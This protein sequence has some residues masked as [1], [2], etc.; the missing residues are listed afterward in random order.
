MKSIYTIS[1]MIYSDKLPDKGTVEYV[2]SSY[3]FLFKA[4]HE[5]KNM[6]IMY[7]NY[8]DKWYDN[9]FNK[10]NLKIIEFEYPDD[11]T[12]ASGLMVDY[13][14]NTY[15]LSNENEIEVEQELSIQSGP[16][17]LFGTFEVM[18]NNVSL[19]E[20]EQSATSL[21]EYDNI[22]DAVMIIARYLQ[23]DVRK[24]LCK[25]VKVLYDY[26]DAFQELEQTDCYH[27]DVL[28]NPYIDEN[29]ALYY[30]LRK[31]IEI[32]RRTS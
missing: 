17:F 10:L 14:N 31:F 19:W 3:F 11:I 18:L 7:M 26:D 23:F 9:A 30:Q 2:I 8:I 21:F 4:Y 13:I 5:S 24:I 25:L 22:S 6:I 20:I 27:Y 29:Y 16:H 32:E 1:P 28:N 12:Y 15:K